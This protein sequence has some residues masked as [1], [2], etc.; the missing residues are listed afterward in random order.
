MIS[1]ADPMLQ[2]GCS[3]R[4]QI[5]AVLVDRHCQEVAGDPATPA[6]GRR[7]ATRASRAHTLPVGEHIEVR[8][9]A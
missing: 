9:L 7:P 8:S 2:R 3:T 1:G 4:L 5:L 6:A